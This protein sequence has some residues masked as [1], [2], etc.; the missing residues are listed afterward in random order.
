MN[1]KQDY[2]YLFKLLLIGNTS[3]GK[4]SLLLRFTDNIFDDCYKLTIGVDFKIKTFELNNKIVKL[5]IWDTAGQE[6]FRTLT[7]SYYKGSHG[8]ILTYDITNRQSF[9]DIENWIA[10][11]E[12]FADR[13]I[14]QLLIGNKS[15]LDKKRNVS[16]EEGQEFANSIGVNFIETSAKNCFNVEKA[17][18]IMANEIKEKIQKDNYGKHSDLGKSQLRSDSSSYYNSGWDCC[19]NN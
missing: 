11:S 10:E 16:K 2:D 13:N 4:S 12:K 1:L 6:R 8:I 5:Q 14:V 17:F 7:N 3:V 18:F 15:D 9:E 19:Y